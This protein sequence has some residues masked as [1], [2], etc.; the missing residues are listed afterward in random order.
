MARE[1][2]DGEKEIADLVGESVGYAA[3][4]RFGD[5]LDLLPDLGEHQPGILPVEADRRGFRLQLDRTGQAG[6]GVRHAIQDP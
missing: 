2:R 5:F 4:D 3:I 1:G 6:Q